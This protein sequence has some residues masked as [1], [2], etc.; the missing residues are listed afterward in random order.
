MMTLNLDAA[1]RMTE[2]MKSAAHFTPKTVRRKQKETNAHTK[3]RH[4]SKEKTAFLGAE[5]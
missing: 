4:D 5:R 2:A 3:T 1:V